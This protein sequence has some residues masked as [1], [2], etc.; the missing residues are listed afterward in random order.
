MAGITLQDGVSEINKY[1][2]KYCRPSKVRAWRNDRRCLEADWK[3]AK[4]IT[5]GLDFSACKI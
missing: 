1:F 4:S 5:S 2:Q 3:M